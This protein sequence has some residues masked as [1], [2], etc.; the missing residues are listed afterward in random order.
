MKKNLILILS[1][2]IASIF[3]GI[4]LIST[5]RPRV[6]IGFSII[7]IITL[8]PL[9]YH[10]DWLKLNEK[11]L[12]KQPLFIASIAVPFQM[13]ILYG[14]WAWNG[15]A[16]DFTSEGF[17]RFLDIS[18]LPLL[19]LASSVPLAAI[20]SN[21]HRTTQTEN[22]IEKTQKQIN[23]VIEKNKTD[24]YYS[25]L[26]SYSDIFQTLPSF[27]LARLKNKDDDA[28]E[29]ELSVVHPYTLYKN[30]FKS[31]SI[32]DGYS[33]EIDESFIRKTQNLYNNINTCLK[34]RNKEHDK[35]LLDIQLVESHIIQLCR[36]LGINYKYQEHMF[37]ILL[38]RPQSDKEAISISFSDEKQIKQMLWGLRDVL[39]ELYVLIDRE[40]HAFRA[41]KSN[42][43]YI[44]EYALYDEKLFDGILPISN[45]RRI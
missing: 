1:Y 13:F 27:K 38:E 37:S 17:N 40:S 30:I 25:H 20:V 41:G 32:E 11:N 45:E 15:H 22:Q 7:Y 21:I 31:S 5:N 8:I 33:T 10:F 9:F 23:L 24:S 42:G 28:E 44:P 43:D 3:I 39:L 26:K 36:L 14:F 2:V 29:I 34:T 6:F 19:M 18:K 35:Q 16:L 12:L 4:F